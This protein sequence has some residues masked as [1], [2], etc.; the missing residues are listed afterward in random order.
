MAGGNSP[1]RWSRRPNTTP[2]QPVPSR[3]VARRIYMRRRVV[4]IL[5]IVT[6]IYVGY[7]G[8]TL[9]SALTNPALGVSLS[10]RGAEW[11]RENNLG[12]AVTWVEQRWY[13]IHKPKQ[14]G[15]AP[16]DSFG[17]GA[18][19]V[20]VPR[21]GHLPKPTDIV[22]PATSPEP[23]EGVWHVAGRLSAKGIPALYEAFV[24]P[25]NI[26][27]SY[28]VGVV[29]MDTTLLQTKLYSGSY[30]PGGGPYQNRSPIL[31]KITGSLVSAFNSGF[32][33]QDARGGYYTDSKVVLPLR[34]GAAS[35]VIFADGTMT[36]AQWGRD[37]TMSKDVV[38]VRQ[39]LDLIVD[40]GAPVPEL[41]NT[42]TL[43]WG[44]TLG[45]R[46]DVWRSGLGVTKNGALV[47]VGGPAMTIHA[48]ADIL[49]RAGAV[50]AMELDINT[51]WVQYSIFRAPLGQIINGG[52]GRSL[53]PSMAGPPSRY[54]TTWWNRDFFTMSFRDSALQPST[55][56]APR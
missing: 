55:T 18:T 14:G 17:S 27:T 10:A 35:A 22:S 44:A 43:K 33:M 15:E 21:E 16:A 28:V 5:T 25:D 42:H 2:P 54:F 20:D 23:G 37:V 41:D 45:G 52:S 19:S 12:W 29:W 24:R 36:V 32:R 47:Y 13:S 26:R 40:N 7:L 4:A 56:N 3:R 1:T 6:S 48:L 30:I 31:P 8:V 39:N 49:T 38:A 50:R 9:V 46:Y 11:G 34:Q 53:L 51:D